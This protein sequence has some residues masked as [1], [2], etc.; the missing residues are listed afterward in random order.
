MATSQGKT[1]EPE[2][3][4]GWR[5]GAVVALAILIV[6]VGAAAAASAVARRQ[7]RAHVDAEVQLLA[8]QVG[9]RVRGCVASR[10]EMLV[11]M[12]REWELGGLPD[13]AAFDAR[14]AGL[15]A[16]F[17]GIF[18]LNQL[19]RDSR[20]T[21]VYPPGPNQRALGRKI[22]ENPVAFVA[23]E[24]A[25]ATV[26]P[27]LTPPV[28][29][30]QGG[31][32]VA[33]YLPIAPDDARPIVLNGVFRSD[34]LLIGCLG[35]DPLVDHAVSLTDGEA[36]LWRQLPPGAPAPT[37]TRAIAVVDRT[38]TLRLGP[39]ATHVAEQH[40]LAGWIFDGGVLLALVAAA[41][42]AVLVVARSRVTAAAAAHR[43]LVLE[44]AQAQRLEAIGR[45]AGGVAHDF[46]NLLTVITSGVGLLRASV[47]DP[48]AAVLLDD[49]DDAARRGAGL[50]RDL[51]ALGRGDAAGAP[52]LDLGEHVRALS[53]L[54]Q[55]LLGR[56][57]RLELRVADA[58]TVVAGGRGALD[59]I[60]VNLVVNAAYA[61]PDGGVVT[62]EVDR[63]ADDVRLVV[64]DHGVGIPPE[65]LARVFEPFFTTKAPGQGT[66]LGLATVDGHVRRLGGSVKVTSVVGAG[67]QVVVRL[68]RV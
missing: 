46:N 64:R 31:V 15:M 16:S 50:T 44:L 53:P 10:V 13:G 1:A 9:E 12:K 32:G 19:D 56:E 26:A 60:L 6:G 48:D 23:F 45:L 62:V 2:A 14:A 42:G 33:L 35:A 24:A 4:A 47:T 20:I 58:P 57:H 37:T 29:L 22:D 67:S 66:G 55:R 52:P 25:L 8:D 51:L 36:L 17:S 68:P 27:R 34:R 40:R 65:V 5:R 3:R 59:Q 18:A 63:D 7:A 30:F 21:R 61:M 49:L 28:T 39:A 11:A 38:W 54:L 43:R 41:L